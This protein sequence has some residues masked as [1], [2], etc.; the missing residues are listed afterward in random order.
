MHEAAGT[1]SH[2][3]L[4]GSN[5]DSSKTIIN[6]DADTHMFCNLWVLSLLRFQGHNVGILC[7]LIMIMMVHVHIWHV[8]DYSCW[9]TAIHISTWSWWF[10]INITIYIFAT[11]NWIFSDMDTHS[12]TPNCQNSSITH[13]VL[14]HIKVIDN[15]YMWQHCISKNKLI[16]RVCAIVRWI[17]AQSKTMPEH[18]C[19]P[20][21]VST[22]LYPS[23]K[24]SL[25]Q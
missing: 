5:Y 21:K 25:T 20:G 10:M 23:S 4:W 1:F 24:L 6:L 8:K 12:I 17:I 19:M 18:L 14:T 7:Q 15:Q 13:S 22:S 11:Y 2:D 9:Y 16:E 3:W